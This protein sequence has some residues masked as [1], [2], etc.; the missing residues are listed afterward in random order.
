[1]RLH[2]PLWAWLGIISIVLVAAVLRL[3]G[4][5][6]SEF[7]D[8]EVSVVWHAAEVIQGRADA[9]FVHDKGPAEILIDD[10]DIHSRTG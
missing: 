3:P 1:M 8:D 2:L 10:L 9:L 4:L 5:G 7:Q 6:Y